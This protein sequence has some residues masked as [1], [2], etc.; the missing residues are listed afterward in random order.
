MEWVPIF[1]YDDGQCFHR[2]DD[3]RT[4]YWRQVH[5]VQ[6]GDA[7][8][9]SLTYTHKMISSGWGADFDWLAWAMQSTFEAYRPFQVGFKTQDGRNHFWHYA[10]MKHTG[11]NV[12][13]PSRDMFCYFYPLSKC[14]PGTVKE[15][16]EDDGITDRHSQPQNLWLKQYLT[17][18]Q[19]WLRKAIYDYLRDET[20]QVPTPCIAMH[21]RRADVVL[22]DEHS[23]KYFQI[24][25]YLR[26]IGADAN[27]RE[28]VRDGNNILLFTDDA[29]A[30]DEAH[31]FHPNYNWVYLNRTRHRGSSG[32][33]ENQVPSQDPRKEVIMLLSILE[34]AKKCDAF[35]YTSSNYANVIRD[36]ML[37]TG[38]SIRLIRV[39]EGLEIHNSNHSLSEAE[40]AQ[41]LMVDQ[42]R[43]STGVS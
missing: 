16:V 37:S 26:K 19:Q 8:N 27:V 13:C 11:L 41:K 7:T 36:T 25:D 1:S 28:L 18:P 2:E 17:R 14:Q 3:E 9:C 24:K 39:D 12:T 33:W 29:N 40:L 30:I 35:A 22:H 4:R 15:S 38:R 21:V 10:A 20:P 6:W 43:S 42:Q 5:E 32:G 23:R 34:M 31:T